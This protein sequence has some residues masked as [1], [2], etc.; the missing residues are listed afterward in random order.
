M[1]AGSILPVAIKKNKLYFLFG[2]EN[3]MEDSAKGWSDFGGRCENNETPREA[4][5][6]EGSEELTGFLGN[7]S[8]IKKLMEKNG[9]P[10]V[11]SHNNYHV[12][13]F[14]MDYDENLPMY[15]NNNHSFLWNNMD[16]KVL[17]DSKLFE[18][19]EIDWFSVKDLT[20]RREEF[21]GFYRDIVDIMKKQIQNIMKFIKQSHNKTKRKYRK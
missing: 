21:R 11:I 6:R 19:I 13:I 3:P 10:Y 15:Y 20:V 5:L 4:A 12:H 7:P 16:N 18:K 14:L 9:E 1:V 8:Q 17:N 2:K